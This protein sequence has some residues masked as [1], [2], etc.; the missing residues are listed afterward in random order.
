MTQALAIQVLVTRVLGSAPSR[1]SASLDNPRPALGF[2]GCF[3]LVEFAST[4]HDEMD[5]STPIHPG[6]SDVSDGL[7]PDTP[8]TLPAA[9]GPRQDPRRRHLSS[10]LG[11]LATRSGALG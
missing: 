2:Q 9:T 6:G 10:D 11:P 4:C 5:P 8:T 3:R 1:R 7:P